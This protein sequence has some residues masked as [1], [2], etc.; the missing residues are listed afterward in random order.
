MSGGVVSSGTFERKGC[1]VKKPVETVNHPAHYGGDT[2]YETI[3]VLRAWLT[4]EQYA[5]FLLGNSL[6]YL[7]R[8]G[9]KSDAV[10]DASKA[11]WYAEAYIQFLK[12]TKEA[13][14]NG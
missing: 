8:V 1:I 2:T 12:E 5:G 11:K 7:S 3:K 13:K 9:K 14:S 4:P 10:E 6:K